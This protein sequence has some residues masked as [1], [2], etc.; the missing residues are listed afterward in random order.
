MA[1]T[2]PASSKLGLATSVWLFTFKCMKVRSDYESTLVC[3]RQDVTLECWTLASHSPF[4]FFPFSRT[5][6]ETLTEMTFWGKK[7]HIFPLSM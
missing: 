6:Q 5:M 7:Y 4:H 2:L 3:S 1:G